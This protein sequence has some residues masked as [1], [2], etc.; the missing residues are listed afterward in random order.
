L[1]CLGYILSILVLFN[2][3][4]Y[5]AFVTP[6]FCY[7]I[8]P[9]LR[10]CYFLCPFLLGIDIFEFFIMFLL[11]FDSFSIA[12]ALIAFD[13]WSDIPSAEFPLLSDL[14]LDLFA[15]IP[16]PWLLLADFK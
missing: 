13:T 8:I 10:E 2:I 1:A 7:S 15:L 5:D 6:S 12:A 11:S 9:F 16:S 3:L 4:S 14:K